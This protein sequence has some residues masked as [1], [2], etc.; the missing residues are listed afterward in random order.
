MET[1]K[2]EVKDYATPS[3]RLETTIHRVTDITIG[4]VRTSTSDCAYCLLPLVITTRD[5]MKLRLELFA[6]KE[7]DLTVRF[8][9]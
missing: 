1:N 8:S 5:G 7:D 3:G 6:D 9:G 2:N 4:R